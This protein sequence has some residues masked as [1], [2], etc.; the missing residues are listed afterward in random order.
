GS[1]RSPAQYQT[2]EAK[3]EAL[4]SLNS[5]GNIPGNRRIFPYVERGDST[6]PNAPKPAR[7]V[8]VESP[9]IIDGAELRSASANPEAS[10]SSRFQIAFSL[11]KNGA[12]KFGAWTA[13]NIN[14]WM[15]VVLNDEGKSIAYIKSQI[16]DTA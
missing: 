12:D 14:E 4:A 9:A 6:T 8:V 11:K 13:A 7:W 10:G 15:G 16:S 2:Y 3:E 5:G 1:P